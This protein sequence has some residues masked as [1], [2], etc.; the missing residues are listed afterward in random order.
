M[1]KEKPVY[2]SLAEQYI[3]EKSKIL[4]AGKEITDEEEDDE[5]YKEINDILEETYL[6]IEEHYRE[7]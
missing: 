7:H 3:E 2:K 4:Y 6:L 1:M 5:E